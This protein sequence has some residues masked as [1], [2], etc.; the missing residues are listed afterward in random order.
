M[1]S[2][3]AGQYQGVAA[4]GESNKASMEDLLLMGGLAPDIP[5]SHVLD[6]EGDFLCYRY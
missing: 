5:V 4:H 2:T 6:T 1:S 3:R